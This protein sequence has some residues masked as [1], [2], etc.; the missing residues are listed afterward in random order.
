M[1]GSN[2]WDYAISGNYFTC[3]GEET[4]NLEVKTDDVDA[5]KKDP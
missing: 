5:D 3:T 2:F 1:H 4:E